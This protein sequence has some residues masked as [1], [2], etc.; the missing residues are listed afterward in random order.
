MIL[1]YEPGCKETEILSC[2]TSLLDELLQIIFPKV[3]KHA[4]FFQTYFQCCHWNALYKKGLHFNYFFQN[5][6][7]HDDFK[8]QL[9]EPLQVSKLPDKTSNQQEGYSKD[10]NG[11]LHVLYLLAEY[12]DF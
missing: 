9:D 5:Y 12:N 3:N 2:A 7:Y 6:L 10:D 11:L 8:E 1:G 4:N